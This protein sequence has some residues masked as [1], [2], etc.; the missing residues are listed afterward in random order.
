MS[1]FIPKDACTS[2]DESQIKKIDLKS[3]KINSYFSTNSQNMNSPKKNELEFSSITARTT[4]LTP[5]LLEFF[6]E[7][8][9]IL[10]PSNLPK[11]NLLDDNIDIQDKINIIQNIVNYVKKLK[12]IKEQIIETNL[13]KNKIISNFD[14]EIK[15]LKFVQKEGIENMKKARKTFNSLSKEV[16]SLSKLIKANRQVCFSVNNFNIT[17]ND[18]FNSFYISNQIYN[19]SYNNSYSSLYYLNQ[20]NENYFGNNH[21]NFHS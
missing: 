10:I 7:I 21:F 13:K 2:I 8:Q 9:Q 14:N 16:K 18:I 5:M 20:N 3:I 4:D 15:N 12:E 1:S 6:N 11:D 19:N 17:N